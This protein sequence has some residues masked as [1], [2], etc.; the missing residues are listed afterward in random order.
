VVHGA[1]MHLITKNAPRG[2]DRELP[3]VLKVTLRMLIQNRAAFSANTW[4]FE[5][6]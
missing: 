1:A 6:R 2:T 5:H 3:S 4:R